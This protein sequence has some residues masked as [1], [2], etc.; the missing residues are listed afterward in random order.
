[1]DSHSGR[2][3]PLIILFSLCHIHRLDST[4]LR[5]IWWVVL[6][7][8]FRRLLM[9]KQEFIQKLHRPMTAARREAVSLSCSTNGAVLAYRKLCWLIYAWQSCWTILAW[10]CLGHFGIQQLNRFDHCHKTLCGI[11]GFKAGTGMWSV[12]Y[13]CRWDIFERSHLSSICPTCC[14]LWQ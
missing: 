14:H 4:F 13:G 2:E 8:T 3:Q 7:N 10:K 5:Q 1:M 9:V 11:L 6:Q 12:Y